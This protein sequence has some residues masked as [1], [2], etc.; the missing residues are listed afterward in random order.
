MSC[1][2]SK[3]TPV[4]GGGGGA[5]HS[6]A[7]SFF[8]RPD[9]LLEDLRA[10][11]RPATNLAHLTRWMFNSHPE[12]EC[13]PRG[14]PFLCSAWSLL[15]CLLHFLP[16]LCKFDVGGACSTHTTSRGVGLL[17]SRGIDGVCL[18]LFASVRGT[19]RALKLKILQCLPDFGK[20]N[21]FLDPSLFT[22]LHQVGV[23][24]FHG[25]V[26]TSRKVRFF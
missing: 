25:L 19:F 13:Q 12:T 14:R 6:R 15:C 24:N 4:L 5:E 18:Q 20:V 26:R 17:H 11:S 22:I 10:G 9:P 16:Q 8:S 2:I 21:N 23:F 3:R 7:S 1:V